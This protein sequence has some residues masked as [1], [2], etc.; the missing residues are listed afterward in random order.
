MAMHQTEELAEVVSIVFRQFNGLELKLELFQ[1][2]RM[3][4]KILKSPNQYQ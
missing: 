2:Y 4:L 3:D 1:V